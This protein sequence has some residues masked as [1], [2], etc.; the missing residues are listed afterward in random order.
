MSD[1]QAMTGLGITIEAKLKAATS[2][3]YLAEVYDIKL[4][5]VA[6]DQHEASHAQSPFGFKEYIDG[7]KDGGELTFSMNYVP[8]S[9]TDAFLRDA[10]GKHDIRVTFPNGVQVLISGN[11]QNYEP[12]GPV[13]DRMTADVSVKVSRKPYMTGAAAPRNITAP[14]I[15]GTPKVGEV[16]SLDPGIWAGVAQDVLTFQWQVDGSDVSGAT[17]LSYIPVTGDVGSP[18][19]C[20]V[21]GDNG[22]F[23]TTVSTAATA[24]F[25]AAS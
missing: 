9:G 8:G 6:T 23:D 16:L 4:P 20:D 11:F 7:M 3:T 22:A 2:Y 19:T 12:T 10:A 17:G 14:S 21:T 18:V 1:T 5:S 13:N 25:A 24:N 15:S